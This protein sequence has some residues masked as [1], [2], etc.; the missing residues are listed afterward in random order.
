[1]DLRNSHGPHGGHVF[2]S[3]GSGARP[4][5][6]TRSWTSN[7][8]NYTV[9]TTS[10]STP[11]FSFGTMTGNANG[12]FRGFTA[13]MRSSGR[14]TSAGGLLGNA[15]GMLEDLLSLQQQQPRQEYFTDHQP[16]MGRRVPIV[17][18]SDTDEDLIIEDYD[19]RSSTR[20][21]LSSKLK[22]LRNK[23]LDGKHKPRE[24][25]GHIRN[26]DHNHS[27]EQSPIRRPRPESR[28]SSFRTEVREPQWSQTRRRPQSEYIEVDYHDDDEEDDEEPEYARQ[29]ARRFSQVEANMIEALENAVESERR[30]ARD[31]KK[32]LELATREPGVSSYNLQKLVNQLKVHEDALTRAQLNLDEAKSKKQ[33]SGQMPQRTRSNQTR[34]KQSSRS[35]EEEFFSPFGAGFDPLFPNNRRSRHPNP[36]FQAFEDMERSAFGND[37]FDLHEQLLEQMRASATM[38][39]NPFGFYPGGRAPAATTGDDTFKYF[40]TGGQPN[41]SRKRTRY[42]MP[43]GG[44]QFQQPMPSFTT[45]FTAPPKQQPPNLLKHDEAQRLFKSYNE[46]WN[47]L[48]ANNYNIPYPARGLQ[49]N[50]L[51][52][53]DTIWA[54]NC[55]ASISTWSNETVHQAN[56]QAFYL[57]VV[58]LSPKYSESPATGRVEMGFDKSQASPQQIKDLVDLLKIERKRWHSDRLGRRNAGMVGPN[59]ALQRDERARA[60]FHAVCELLES[61]Q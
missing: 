2:T 13:P 56:A 45:P 28:Q 37:P 8:V 20:S 29:Q 34:P 15:F 36:A 5:R 57:G 26:R 30:S 23:L 27:R 50:S 10:F 46:R 14:S 49:A 39:D 6:T 19:D 4:S 53:R 24:G 31:C 18:E 61:A 38:N 42:S 52:A 11:G 33:R 35:L 25:R 9:D 40:A 1:M 58:G 17:V 43:S 48:P 32:R 47:A 3:I 51:A 12:G 16:G 54:P 55:T 60:V 22:G 21:M 44:P 41:T 59:E 7:G